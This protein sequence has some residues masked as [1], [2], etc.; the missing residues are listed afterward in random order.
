MT[1]FC[2]AVSV[3]SGASLLCFG[4]NNIVNRLDNAQVYIYEKQTIDIENL[5]I[6]EK[7][8]D[9]KKTAREGRVSFY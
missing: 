3:S 8:K 2:I 5:P 7:R 6:D 1:V 4:R 9:R